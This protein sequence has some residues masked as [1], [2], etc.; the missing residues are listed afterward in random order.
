MSNI[1]RE[2]FDA[3]Q[4][5]LDDEGSAAMAPETLA[6]VD[7]AITHSRGMKTGDE[8][9]QAV[10]DS[11]KQEQFVL[12]ATKESHDKMTDIIR[13]TSTLLDVTER[14]CNV[15]MFRGKL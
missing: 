8:F 11:M 6:A 1:Q 2:M 15:I 7:A 3:L 12:H 4:A 13:N 10:R 14:A 9:M 5:V